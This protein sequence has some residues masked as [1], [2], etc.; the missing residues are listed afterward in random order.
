MSR[1]NLLALGAGVVSALL[2]LSVV[3]G[4]PGAVMLAY[5]SQLP[6]FMVGF[7]LGLVPAAIASGVAFVGVMS[8]TK[9]A[10][11]T[12]FLV[13]SVVPVLLIVRQALLNRQ[14]PDGSTEWYPPGLIL[15]W[16]TAL[17]LVCLGG[18]ALA[19]IGI[20]GG[21]RGA[22]RMFLDRLVE[23]QG[24][25]AT[26]LA[27]TLEAL[28]TILPAAVIVS[29]LIM[30]VINATMAQGIL[31][32]SETALRP[33][34]RYSEMELPRWPLAVLAIAF[35]AAF[36]P[37]AFGFLGRNAAIVAA[38]PFVFL[39]LA[40]VHFASRRWPARGVTLTLTYATVL[41]LGW[42]AVLLAGLGIIDQ[43]TGLRRR[44][45]GGQDMEDE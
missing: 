36:L 20:E 11:M 27:A 8:A 4:A 30:V 1:N 24:G 2:Y 5:F 29:G 3:L 44:L 7:G 40:V 14:A 16:L 39:G 34:P 21:L 45:S 41:L 42:P 35:A 31:V 18:A 23:I 33:S 12:V 26:Q 25:A 15:S 37:G 43:W 22:G 19:T 17:G 38:T 9:F 6:L 28:E 10:A 32:R 13:S